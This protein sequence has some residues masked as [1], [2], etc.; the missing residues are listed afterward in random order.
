[1]QTAK[2]YGCY[3]HVTR[4]WDRAQLEFIGLDDS[5]LPKI[6]S[7]LRVAGLLLDGQASLGLVSPAPVIAGTG[8]TFAALVTAGA[9]DAGDDFIYCG[10]F[11]LCATLE[12]DIH[13]II[14]GASTDNDTVLRGGCRCLISADN[15]TRW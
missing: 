1:M 12:R 14:S 2:A 5:Q 8:D 10:T 15:L 9:A 11:G 7:P 6:M 3:D 13:E 4:G